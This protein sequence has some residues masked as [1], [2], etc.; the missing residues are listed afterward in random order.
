MRQVAA[1]AFGSVCNQAIRQ[2]QTHDE[3]YSPAVNA[4]LNFQLEQQMDEM[5]ALVPELETVSSHVTAI[6]R[7]TC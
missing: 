4:A 2:D 7:Y 5:V 6:D 3:E 1:S